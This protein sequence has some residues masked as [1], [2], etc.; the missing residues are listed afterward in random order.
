MAAISSEAY[1]FDEN[2]P[3]TSSLGAQMLLG[4]NL[5]EE[6]VETIEDAEDDYWTV[7]EVSFLQ[8]I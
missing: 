5:L 7:S 8:L 1:E 2:I 6:E 4:S 3:S